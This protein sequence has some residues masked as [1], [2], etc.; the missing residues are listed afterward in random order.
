LA[1]SSKTSK[2]STNAGIAARIDEVAELLLVANTRY[3]IVRYASKWNISSRQVDEYM[4][5]AWA[6]IK[7]VN[8]GDFEENRSMVLRNFWDIYKSS[9]KKDDGKTAIAAL[10]QISKICGLDQITIQHN[11]KR[12]DDL[13]EE[14]LINQAIAET[15]EAEGDSIH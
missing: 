15:I 5:R 1:K 10:T 11:I 3:Q 4:A 14:E 2:K 6:Q 8:A 12:F 9:K 13:S 7:E